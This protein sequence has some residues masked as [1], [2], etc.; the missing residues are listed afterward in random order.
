MLTIQFFDRL[1]LWE[2]STT[3]LFAVLRKRGVSGACK[4]PADPLIL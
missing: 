4:C 1:L 2:V 3:P